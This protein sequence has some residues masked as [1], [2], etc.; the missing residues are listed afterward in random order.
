MSEPRITINGVELTTAEAMTIRVACSSFAADLRDGLGDDEIGF[1]IC[2]GYN[3][4]LGSIFKAIR[5][6]DEKE[7]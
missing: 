5:R 4:A 7:T 3:V 6:Y 1:S 2:R